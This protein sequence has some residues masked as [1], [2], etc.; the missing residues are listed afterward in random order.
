M[1][2]NVSE[3]WQSLHDWARSALGLDLTAAQIDQLRRF[4]DTLQLWNRR[5]ALV[6]QHDVGAIL[7]KHVADSL[8]AAA[9]CGM[10]RRIADLG[11]GAGFPG[12]PLA[13][14]R[15][16]A[17][18]CLMESIG[19]KVSFLEEARRL[20]GVTNL[21]VFAGRIEH[22][23]TLPAHQGA[24]D[25]VTARALTDLG[26]LQTLAAPLLTTGGRLMAMRAAAAGAPPGSEVIPYDLPDDTPREL[27]ILRS[28]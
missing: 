17:E 20:A 11:S 6:S 19:K 8:V 1:T 4:V 3:L 23:W 21:T 13:I 7:N 14:L 28:S 24:Y 27:V 2:Q 26:G 5:M 9:R 22:A 18:V 12:I 25:L 15:P 16:D 10:P